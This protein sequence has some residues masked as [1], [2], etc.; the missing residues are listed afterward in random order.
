MSTIKLNDREYYY[1][2]LARRVLAVAMVN[3]EVGDWSAYIDAVPGA[4]HKKE[5]IFVASMGDKLPEK[6]ATFIFPALAEKYQ[7]RG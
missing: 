3:E 4:D 7:W 5:I 1:E 6:L 2:S